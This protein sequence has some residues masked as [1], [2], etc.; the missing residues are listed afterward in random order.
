M[1]KAILRNVKTYI[2]QNTYVFDTNTQ[3]VNAVTVS[4]KIQ[5]TGLDGEWT[6]KP[7][8]Q[9]NNAF[10]KTVRD[11]H[12]G[13]DIA[14]RAC[15]CTTHDF[16]AGVANTDCYY[17]EE[18]ISH[19]LTA[20]Q[21]NAGIFKT[22]ESAWT[23]AKDTKTDNAIL[24]YI[25]STDNA[26]R[27]DKRGTGTKHDY[28]TRWTI[29]TIYKI[30]TEDMEGLDCVDAEKLFISSILGVKTKTSSWLKF[31]KTL[32][33]TTAGK[34]QIV[35]YLFSY[36]DFMELDDT[37]AGRVKGFNKADYQFTQEG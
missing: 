30:K 16:V 13:D 35:E 3:I 19:S 25:A 23:K 20:T 14:T 5:G 6:I 28:W 1:I 29:G 24:I 27:S 22:K 34:Y 33:R 10:A 8:G 12:D 17:G 36:E 4:N 37:I 7:N 15:I 2:S 9:L 26:D 31:E 32:G 11:T 21:V 18:E